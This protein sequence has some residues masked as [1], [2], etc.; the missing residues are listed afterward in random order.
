M[1]LL[2]LMM[3]VAIQCITLTNIDGWIY[4]RRFKGREGSIE[5]RVKVRERGSELE[6]GRA[7]V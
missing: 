1:P 7:H 6:I 2:V 3:A 5:I 4:M